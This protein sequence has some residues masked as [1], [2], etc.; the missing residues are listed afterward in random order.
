[1]V[2]HDPFKCVRWIVHIYGSRKTKSWNGVTARTALT[3]VDTVSR[4]QPMHL[5]ARLSKKQMPL[6]NQVDTL[7]WTRLYER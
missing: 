5:A 1:M 3:R 2:S 4:C 7:T 6:R